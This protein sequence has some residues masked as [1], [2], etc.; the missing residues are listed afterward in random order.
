M[1]YMQDMDMLLK[2]NDGEI[3]LEASHGTTEIIPV[4]RR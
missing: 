1:R 4:H 3:I 2:R